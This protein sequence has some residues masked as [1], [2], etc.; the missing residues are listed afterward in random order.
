MQTYE[1]LYIIRPEVAEDE[2]Q[3]IVDEAQKLVTDQNGTIVRSEVWGK[4]RLAYEVKKQTEGIYVLLRFTAEMAA[5]PKLEM[6]FRL[7]EEILRY[8]NVKF[9]E[10]TLRLEAEQAIRKEQELARQG[11]PEGRHRDDDDD[12]DDD[13]DRPRRRPRYE[14]AGSSRDRD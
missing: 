1:A 4:R 3:T 8:M 2:V 12:D 13:D 9:D 7:K 5:L 14:T 6:Y 11:G 10:Q